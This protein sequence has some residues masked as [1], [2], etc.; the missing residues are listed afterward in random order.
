VSVQNPD[1]S[2][3]VDFSRAFD[4]EFK[5]K[6]DLLNLTLKFY[7]ETIK[8]RRLKYSLTAWLAGAVNNNN[9][10]FVWGGVGWWVDDGVRM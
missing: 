6:V 3:G 4:F 2:F 7:L 10:E 1:P 8:V 5:V 9:R